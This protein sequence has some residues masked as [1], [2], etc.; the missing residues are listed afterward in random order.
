M[1][2]A[3]ICAAKNA[4]LLRYFQSLLQL[5]TEYRRYFCRGEFLRP[6]K[7]TVAGKPSDNPL[8]GPV[9]A[10]QWRDPDGPGS[11]IF[12]VNV[13]RQPVRARVQKRAVLLAP[14]AAKVIET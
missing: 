9:L 14:L 8:K 3:V 5:R 4:A 7:I 12:L 13:T 6:P 11:A 2:I 1:S 10:A